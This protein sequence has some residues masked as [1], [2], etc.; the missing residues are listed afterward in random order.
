VEVKNELALSMHPYIPHLLND[1]T[2]A[3]R[4]EKPA[5]KEK[6]ALQKFW[7]KSAG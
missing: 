6:K 2:A 4:T 7:K 3:H 5:R 1:I